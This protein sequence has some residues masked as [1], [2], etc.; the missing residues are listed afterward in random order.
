MNKGIIVGIVA[1]L[2]LVVIVG[3]FLALPQGQPVAQVKN[4]QLEAKE[5]GFNDF[6]GGPKIIVKA[7][8]TVKV[9]LKN[10]GGAP[11][12]FMVFKADQMQMGDEMEMVGHP[13]PYFKGAMTE[14]VKPGSSATI[15]FVADK[16]GN[17]VYACLLDVGTKPDSHADRGMFGEFIVEG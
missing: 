10:V 15:T 5:F 17:Y 7:G 4:I 14:E 6:K 1:V 9:T 8:E 3:S 13:D 16:P 2:A 12:E 11:H